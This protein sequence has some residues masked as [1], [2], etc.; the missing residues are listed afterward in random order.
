MTGCNQQEI[1]GVLAHELGH[2][3]LSHTLKLLAISQVIQHVL[4]VCIYM[5]T[6]SLTHGADVGGLDTHMHE[7]VSDVVAAG[8]GVAA[9]G[10]R[11]GLSQ[12]SGSICQLILRNGRY[13]GSCSGNCFPRD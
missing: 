1:L 9:V 2:W 5:Y 6:W 3:S 7:A 4:H 8:S 13:A 12:A 11:V 10:S